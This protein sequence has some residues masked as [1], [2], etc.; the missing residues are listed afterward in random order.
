MTPFF[1]ILTP[2]LQRESLVAC[3]ESVNSQTLTSWQHVVM[4]DCADYDVG[5]MARIAHPQRVI[6]KCEKPHRNW[7]NSCRHNA[8]KYATGETEIFLDDDNC[9]LDSTTL[10][11][12][13]DHLEKR[14]FPNFAIFP[15]FRHGSVFYN[16]PPAI[17]M[18]DTGNIVV[19]RE[20]GRWLDVPDATSDGMLAEKLFKEYGCVGFSNARPIIVMDESHKGKGVRTG[21]GME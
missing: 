9:L 12:V 5:L 6:V 7:A 17:C 1:T 3:C 18:T 21:E 20:I 4:V 14:G 19:K 10:Q 16:Y 8:W 13:H 11:E 2:T 15:I